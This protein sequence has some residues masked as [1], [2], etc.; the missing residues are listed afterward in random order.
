[1]RAASA[2]RGGSSGGR[3]AAGPSCGGGGSSGGGRSGSSSPPCG[4]VLWPLGG[5]QKA[6]RLGGQRSSCFSSSPAAVGTGAVTPPV[7]LRLRGREAGARRGGGGPQAAFLPAGRPPAGGGG[8][9][10]A[11]GPPRAL[12]PSRDRRRLPRGGPAGVA[13][14]PRPQPPSPLRARLLRDSLRVCFFVSV[15][16]GG[17]LLREVLQTEAGIW[18]SCPRLSLSQMCVAGNSGVGVGPRKQTNPKSSE[19]RIIAVCG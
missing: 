12:A 6:P 9:G 17:N 18:P 15:E 1:M 14:L 11:L 16:V 3:G 8:W 4:L 19:S 10:G 2:P 7:R 5:A 13:E